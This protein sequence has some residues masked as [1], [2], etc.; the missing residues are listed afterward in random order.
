MADLLTLKRQ[1]AQLRMDVVDAVY[2]NRSG[3]IG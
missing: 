1:A 3:H 2:R